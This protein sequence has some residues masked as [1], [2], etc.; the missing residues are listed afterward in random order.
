MSE[1]TTDKASQLEG[2]IDSMCKTQEELLEALKT[3]VAELEATVERMSTSKLH[4]ELRRI[5]I[6]YVV[7]NDCWAFL[8]EGTERSLS[9]LLLKLFGYD[10]TTRLIVEHHTDQG[11]DALEAFMRW[12]GEQAIFFDETTTTDTTAI[13]DGPNLQPP[14]VQRDLHPEDEA[15]S[16]PLS[17]PV[18]NEDNMLSYDL[19]P[20][21]PERETER[22]RRG[23]GQ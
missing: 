14:I 8:D 23:D 18:P 11:E 13:I 17:V 5:G 4:Q 6:K 22:S 7:P 9:A 12:A 19:M 1:H 15:P 21:V 2:A 10:K 20:E 3:R 16:T